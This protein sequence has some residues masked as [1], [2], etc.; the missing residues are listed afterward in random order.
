MTTSPFSLS[1]WWTALTH[2]FYPELCV[3][4]SQAIPALNSC[5]CMKCRVRLMRSDMHLVPENEFTR[6]FWGRIRLQTAA[7]MY[8]FAKKSPIQ[9]AL[10]RLK[11]KNQPDVGLKIGREFGR[12]LAASDLFRPVDAIVAVPLHP[13]KERLRGYNQSAMFA[14]GLSEGMDRPF[15]TQALVRKA[16][17]VSQ[18]RKRR[19]ERFEN[20]ET[21]FAVKDAHLLEGRH[22]LLVDDVL[23]TGATLEAC[24]QVLLQVPGLRLSMATIAIAIGKT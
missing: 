14:R 23:T 3:A 10:H 1:T 17:T 19:M 15:L 18:T 2:L 4:C 5:F 8:Y 13:K 12:L 22:V 20:V 24:G 11:Y 6:R 9:R 21:V 16:F 7:A